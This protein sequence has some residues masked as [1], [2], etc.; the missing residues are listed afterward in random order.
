LHFSAKQSY[1]LFDYIHPDAES[2]MRQV[3]S[4]F[5]LVVLLSK[6]CDFAAYLPLLRCLCNLPL[7]GKGR[8][9]IK[10]LLKLISKILTGL[11]FNDWRQTPELANE[12]SLQQWKNKKSPSILLAV[13]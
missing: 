4:I 2:I 11:L 6:M 8:Q 5:R 13:N 7:R 1:D 10:G 12:V 3:Y 9:N